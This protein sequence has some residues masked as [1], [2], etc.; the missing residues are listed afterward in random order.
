MHGDKTSAK[1]FLF[2]NL[3]GADKLEDLPVARS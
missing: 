2:E 1:K 3:K